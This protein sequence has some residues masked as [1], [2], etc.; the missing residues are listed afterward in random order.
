VTY[1]IRR[2]FFRKEYEVIKEG[3]TLEEAQEHCNDPETSWQ[4]ATSPEAQ[5][6]TKEFGPWFDGYTEV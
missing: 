2:F 3:L 5:K 4:I 6:R 1:E